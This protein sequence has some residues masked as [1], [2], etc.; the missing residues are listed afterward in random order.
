MT[1]KKVKSL[2][3]RESKYADL[4]LIRR[5][6]HKTNFSCALSLTDK[7]ILTGIANA[8]NDLADRKVI[9]LTDAIRAMVRYCEKVEP[10]QLNKELGFNI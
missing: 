5:E 1:K 10:K 3:I 4:G 6:K 8:M 2:P 7:Q 9:T